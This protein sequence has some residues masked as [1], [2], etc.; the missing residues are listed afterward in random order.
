M[1]GATATVMRERIKL[2]ENR[3]LQVVTVE[4]LS[5]DADGT[6]SKDLAAALGEDGLYGFLDCVKT[7]PGAQTPSADWDIALEDESNADLAGGGL[8]DR[9]A[10]AALIKQF[11]DRP[12]LRG[13]VSMEI[14]GAGNAKTGTVVL[15]ILETE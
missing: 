10:T 4:W 1:A 9:S 15:Y 11:A 8:A 2:P 14:S 13:E 5:D 12:L 3:A 6:C 7:V